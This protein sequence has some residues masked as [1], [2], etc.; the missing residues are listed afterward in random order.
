M[1]YLRGCLILSVEKSFHVGMCASIR[2]GK[3]LSGSF[4]VKN[5]LRQ[6]CTLVPTLSTSTVVQWW[7]AGGM[8]AR[9][10]EWK[11]SIATMEGS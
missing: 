8:V 3:L 2:V 5:G 4:E 6:G 9:R 7:Q 10:L 1:G 11:F